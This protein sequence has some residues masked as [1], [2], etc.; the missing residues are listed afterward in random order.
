MKQRVADYIADFLVENGVRHLFSVTGGGAMHLNDAFGHHP[1]LK[2]IYNHHESACAMAAEAYCRYS[3]SIAAICVT[4]GPGGTNALTGVLGGWL[5]SIPMLILSG[6]VKRAHTT[7]LRPA[8]GLR[9]LGDQEFDIASTVQRMTKYAVT[10]A[11]PFDIAY[12]LEKAFF[13]ATEGRGGPVWLDIPLDVQGAI[14]DTNDLHHF[15]ATNENF[16]KTHTV[17]A[18][19]AK[20]ILARIAHAKRPLLLVGTGVRLSGTWEALQALLDK[21][22]IPVLTAWNAG[23]SVAFDNP[24]FAGIP[25][26]VGTRAGNLALGRCDLLLSLGCRLNIRTIGHNPDDF[27]KN[28][29]KIIVDIDE[30]E[31]KKPT[32]T[33]DFPVHADLREL[34]PALL[35]EDYQSNAIHREWCSWC[36]RLVEHFY[37]PTE[38]KSSNTGVIN[39]YTFLGILFSHLLSSDRI[40]CSN[41]SA[42]VMTFQAARIKKGQRMFTN[43]GCASMGYGLPAA[44]GVASAEKGRVIC[45]EGDGS[46]MM[47]L[48]ELATVSHHNM[49]IKIILLNNNGYHSIR[50]TQSTC[51]HAPLIGVDTETG[52][53]FPNFSRLADAFSIPYRKIDSTKTATTLLPDILNSQGPILAEIMIDPT[54]AFSPKVSTV[55][56]PDGKLLSPP[57]DDMAPLLPRDVLESLRR[58]GEVGL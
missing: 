8:Y 1:T 40:I 48:Q 42:C 5:D 13:L 46:I 39:P 28:A 10:I 20:D 43:S 29:W 26:T 47:N 31:L 56:M 23:D 4:S 14:I 55:R 3:G 49:D 57:L 22:Q 54:Q 58:G 21:L 18:Q 50:Q 24:L 34:I 35:A 41:G 52:V 30:A 17:P 9:Q 19:T 7:H 32:V 27:A 11:E 36:H 53:S 2:C 44:L 25:G 6:Q 38:A 37:L 15:D 45:I 16:T 12:H 33:P 51:F